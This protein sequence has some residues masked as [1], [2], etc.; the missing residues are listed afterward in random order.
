MIEPYTK[1]IEEQ[2]QECIGNH[3][4]KYAKQVILNL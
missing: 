3:E 2:M 1:E 4:S